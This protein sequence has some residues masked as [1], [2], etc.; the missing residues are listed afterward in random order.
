MRRFNTVGFS[1]LLN[2][3]F[4]T[5]ENSTTYVIDVADFKYHHKNFLKDD[6]GWIIDLLKGFFPFSCHAQLCPCTKFTQSERELNSASF[7]TGHVLGF[8]GLAKKSRF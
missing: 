8:H 7:D 1:L 3:S 4:L 6:L 2:K 5:S